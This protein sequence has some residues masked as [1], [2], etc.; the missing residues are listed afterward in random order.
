MNMIQ[1]TIIYALSEIQYIEKVYIISNSTVKDAIFASNILSVFPGL[2][3]YKNNV[4]I[5]NKL[6]HLNKKINNGDRI[7][8]Y[9]NLIIDPKERRR[10]QTL[11][12]KEH[13]KLKKIK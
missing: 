5:Y 12:Y 7:E 3:F 2:Q 11:R 10:K 13:L 9:R 4:G 6:V 1:V 8:I